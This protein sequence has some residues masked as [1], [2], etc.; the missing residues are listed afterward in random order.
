MGGGPTAAATE[1]EADGGRARPSPSKLLARM[2]AGNQVQQALFVAAKLGL[3]GL[4]L[5]TEAIA[6]IG[7]S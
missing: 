5:E 3:P 1:R 7:S 6:V 2:L 4:L